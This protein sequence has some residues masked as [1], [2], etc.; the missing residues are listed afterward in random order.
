MNVTSLPDWQRHRR[1]LKALEPSWT[2]ARATP[3]PIFRNLLTACSIFSY[4]ASMCYLSPSV[5]I[6][7]KYTLH[8]RL[9][10]SNNWPST[11]SPYQQNHTSDQVSIYPVL[12]LFS[13]W[14]PFTL[15]FHWPVL[16]GKYNFG[17][18]LSV[19]VLQM[20]SCPQNTR[21][22]KHLRSCHWSHCVL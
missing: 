6:L 18:E 3:I 12:R 4:F 5:A 8:C 13:L 14:F 17:E 11:W 10:V 9:S 22:L 21:L 19:C 7:P 20:L 16:S 15:P 1:A 2:L